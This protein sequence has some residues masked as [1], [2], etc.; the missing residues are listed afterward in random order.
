MGDQETTIP[1]SGSDPQT[2]DARFFRSIRA[3]SREGWRQAQ[4]QE[5]QGREETQRARRGFRR[6]RGGQD[7]D[8]RARQSAR[9][10]AEGDGRGDHQAAHREQPERSSQHRAVQHQ[11]ARV[12]IRAHDRSARDALRLGRL[13]PPSRSDAAKQ[14]L[15]LERMEAEAI[16]EYERA[17]AG[18]P[19]KRAPGE[20]GEGG[21]GGDD[22]GDAAD[23]D[24]D[25]DREPVDDSKA[26]RNQFN[27]SERA[28]QTVNNPTRERQ[29]ATEPPP[30]QQF[31]ASATQWGRCTTRTW[32]ISCAWR[33]RG[34]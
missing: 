15:Q 30:S 4:G 6:L 7:R 25:D 31:T 2:D 32:R 3:G 5:G 23:D 18:L 12:Q 27:F 20:E 9:A 33:S 21:E 13:P 24:D 29:S 34:T 8:H 17:V 14:Q 10:H 26:L 16:E 11:G 19:K 1:S 22:G 28:A